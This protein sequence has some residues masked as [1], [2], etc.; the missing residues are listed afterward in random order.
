MACMKIAVALSGGVDSAT[1]LYLLKQAGYDVFGLF[2][3]NWEE[4]DENG[5]CI[6]EKDAEDARLV[7]DH[8]GVPF[9]GVN[10][11]KEYWDNVFTHFLEEL[12][13]GH[14]P[15]PD[16]LCNREIKFK[17]LFHKAKALG[18]DFL[19]T[20]HYCQTADGK[21]FKGHDQKKD[22][23]Y[24]LYTAKKAVLKEVLF[25]IGQLEKSEVRKI[26]K[27]AN[28]PV[29]D[30]KDSTGICFIGKRNFR[31]FLE[32]YIPH[33]PGDI[34]TVEGEK[35]GTH[36]GIY[37]YTI[38][39][40]K[41]IGI[42][43]AGAPWF[44]AGK[45]KK[46]QRLIVAQGKN[47]PALHAPALSATEVSWVD[48]VPPFPFRCKAKIRYRQTEMPCTVEEEGEKLVVSFDED[49]RAITPRQSVVFY[50][51]EICLGGAIIEKALFK[52]ES[53]QP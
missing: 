38:G 36:D 2:M 34:V 47:H 31:A 53:I 4:E 25:P 28:L 43:G 37:Y 44:V 13:Y 6:A 33:E 16:I 18:A 35:V 24:F 7:C 17:V 10:F 27:E 42:G 51:G 3:K 15:N 8:L 30:K 20:G 9:Y 41:S 50:Q 32:K 21:L 49:Q 29:F 52:N 22:Q 11:V 45:D 46:N 1:S 14:T 26:A 40:R 5:V 23:S 12:K 48:E 19:A 39:Q